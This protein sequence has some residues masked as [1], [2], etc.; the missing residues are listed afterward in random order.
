MAQGTLRKKTVVKA[1][2]SR[3][4]GTLE[5]AVVESRWGSFMA[6][7]AR[8]SDTSTLAPRIAGPLGILPLA[9]GMPLALGLLMLG[10][11]LSR[12]QA[13]GPGA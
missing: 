12:R 3:G 13:D 6:A 2:G 8:C 4:G 5:E 1:A 7:R 10:L 11:R 9:L